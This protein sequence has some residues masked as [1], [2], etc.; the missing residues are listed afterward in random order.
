MPYTT[1][2]ERMSIEKGCQE[3]EMVMLRRL[4]TQRFEPLPEGGR[5]AVARRHG[6][7]P[8]APG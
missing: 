1:S 8:G 2:I 5:A 6:A 3:G 7:G 4:L